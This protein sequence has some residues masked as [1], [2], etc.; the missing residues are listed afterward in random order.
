MSRSICNTNTLQLSQ[1]R[2][3]RRSLAELVIL[4]HACEHT[5]LAVISVDSIGDYVAALLAHMHSPSNDA[6]AI[7]NAIGALSPSAPLPSSVADE[8]A[9]VIATFTADNIDKYGVV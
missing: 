8:L 9:R 2:A 3:T 5:N 4:L 1:P 6:S 7:T